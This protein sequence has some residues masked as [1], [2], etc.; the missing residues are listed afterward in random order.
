MLRCESLESRDVP[1]TLADVL[2]HYEPGTLD[3]Q[4][5]AE[6]PGVDP[7]DVNVLSVSPDRDAYVAAGD[8]L[9][10]RVLIRDTARGVFTDSFFVFDPNYRH[11][12]QSET[13]VGNELVLAPGGDKGGPVLAFVDLTTY[14]VRN[15]LLSVYPDNWRGALHL[16]TADIDATNGVPDPP[17]GDEVLTI[18]EGHF[19]AIDPTTGEVRASFRVG[20][21]FAGTR[22]VVPGAGVSLP[23]EERMGFFVEDAAGPHTTRSYGWD[24]VPGRY[25]DPFDAL[26][27]GGPAVV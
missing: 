12:I 7:A 6:M 27:A 3:A 1:A 4:F 26:A 17:G 2:P 15:V 22:F 19:A 13:V 18:A 9:G 25:S 8:G 16:S 21:Q 23:G 14:A 24:G 20:D 5:A 10:P 11:G